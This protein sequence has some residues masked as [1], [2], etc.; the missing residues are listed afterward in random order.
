MVAARSEGAEVDRVRRLAVNPDTALIRLERYERAA[1]NRRVVTS[2]RA[3]LGA[4]ENLR[5]SYQRAG[6]HP[7][8]DEVLEVI[9]TDCPHC[10]A[11]DEV[12]SPMRVVPRRR[13]REDAKPVDDLLTIFCGACNYHDERSL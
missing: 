5:R 7:V 9:Y 6:L 4:L 11:G 1:E 10:G 3:P 13:Y 12:Y 8:V 2:E